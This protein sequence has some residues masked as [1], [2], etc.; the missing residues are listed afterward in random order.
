MILIFPKS[1]EQS[2]FI[3]TVQNAATRTYLKIAWR[4]RRGRRVGQ[5]RGSSV[6]GT[7]SGRGCDWRPVLSR[8]LCAS[9]ARS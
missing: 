6:R 9:T 7:P 1:A 2:L 3:A 5:N 8:K 4:G